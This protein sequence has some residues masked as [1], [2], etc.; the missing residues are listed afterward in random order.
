VGRLIVS[1][2][3]TAD[4]VMNHI[5]GW[6]NPWLEAEAYGLGGQEGPAPA[7]WALDQVNTADALLLG[8]LTYEGLSQVWP[9]MS[10]PYGLADRINSMP[11]YVASRTLEP[12]LRWNASLIGGDLAGRVA[13]LKRDLPGNLLTY[14]CGELAWHL[15]RH[16]LVDELRFWL[17]PVV[18]G[19]GVRPFQAGR[20]PVRLSLISAVTFSSGLVLLCYR[21]DQPGDGA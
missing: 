20:P 21:P 19:E 18:W 17:F 12:P 7:P 4:A 13:E 16:G 9:T 11:K 6:F 2:Q 15:A 1:A 10:D 5:E 14:G 8:R 3:M